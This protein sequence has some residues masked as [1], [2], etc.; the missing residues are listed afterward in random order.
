MERLLTKMVDF[1]SNGV[2][3]VKNGA[4]FHSNGAINTEWV[5]FHP[6]WFDL[7]QKCRLSLNGSRFNQS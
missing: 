1:H 4:T 2:T 6:R 3:P 7:N 5:S